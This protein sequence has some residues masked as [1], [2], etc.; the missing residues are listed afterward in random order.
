MEFG[1]LSSLDG[2]EFEL[3]AC[4]P[5]SAA[6]LEAVR[7]TSPTRIRIGAPAW[8]HDGYVGKIYPA[9]TKRADYLRRF[10]EQFEA[11]ELNTTYYGVRPDSIA[12]WAE[13]VPERFRFCPKFPKEISHD[14]A[15]RHVEAETDRFFDAVEGFGDR[16]G[17][18]W[19]VPAPG[20]APDSFAA[21]T[22]F[23]RHATQRHPIA[24]E[25]RHPAWFASAQWRD[26][27][28]DLFAEHGITAVLTDVAGRRDVLHMRVTASAVMLRLVGNAGRFAPAAP[29]SP[30]HPTDLTRAAAWAE[31]ITQ[32]SDAGLR[33]AYV[34]FHQATDH[35][36]VEFAE[37]FVTA[38][39]PASTL[40]VRGLT[41]APTQQALF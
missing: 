4:D 11:I 17:L 20:F 6:Q 7:D 35:H 33:S 34:F 15:L 21:L 36:N 31:R 24:V 40:E 30:L 5:A 38:L 18:P 9:G 29:D 25:L 27:V 37:H 32:W 10:A 41:R 12:A 8:G 22:Q 13:Q 2:V 26:R 1:K 28:L 39:R 14:H 23:V 3:P 19:I 16:L